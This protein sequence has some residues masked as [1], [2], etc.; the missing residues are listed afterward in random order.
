MKSC[1]LFLQEDCI[2]ELLH[3]QHIQSKLFL[4]RVVDCPLSLVCNRESVSIVNPYFM[5]MG[6]TWRWT[7][8][9]GDYKQVLYST[10]Y[11]SGLEVTYSRIL[12]CTGP[13]ASMCNCDISSYA[14]IHPSVRHPTITPRVITKPREKVLNLSRL[15]DILPAHISEMIRP[16][17]QLFPHLR[18]FEGFCD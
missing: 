16:F 18:D 13:T 2:S 7:G 15:T 8:L 14:S 17:W 5:A 3:Q 6:I 4:S 1:F 11:R 12:V 10:N 9:E